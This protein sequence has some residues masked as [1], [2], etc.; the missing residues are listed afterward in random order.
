MSTPV[1]QM[2]N[3][4]VFTNT[5]SNMDGSLYDYIDYA[6]T[7][8]VAF[9]STTNYAKGG[10]GGGRKEAFNGAP[11][12]TMKFS[13]QIIT[14]KLISMLSGCNV[15]SD[16]NI[17]KHAK[18]V[19]V[20]NETNTTITFPASAVPANGTLSVFPKGVELVDS[21]KVDG[22][23]TGGVF[24]FTEKATS[25]TAYNCFYR[26]VITGSQTIPFKSNVTPK[27]FIWDGETPWKSNGVERTEQFHAYKVTPQQNFTFSYENTGD[28][29][30][31]EITFDLLS[32]DDNNLFDKTFLPE[33][34]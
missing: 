5:F 1:E 7:G 16:K 15:E 31:L 21:N 29:G 11:E 33:E 13:T 3:R 24:T 10:Q 19:S 6:N 27:S 14:P 32:D 17:F 22:T 30:K 18:I 4:E 34:E 8:D 26:T 20:T 23:L 2:A 25:D 12:V 9:K 28:P